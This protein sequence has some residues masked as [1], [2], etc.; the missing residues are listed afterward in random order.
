M[1]RN[2]AQAELESE[3]RHVLIV[4]QTVDNAFAGTV[5]IT[6]SALSLNVTDPKAS[7][8]WVAA[9]LGFAEEMSADGFVSMAHPQAGVNL[10]YLRVGLPTFTPASA[11]GHADGLLIAFVVDDLD[12]EYD[13]M[14][15]EGVEF[16]ALPVTEPW[17]E[18]YV[19][20]A[21][22]NGVVYQLVTWVTPPE[23]EAGG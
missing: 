4:A 8:D 22:P 1:G 15:R 21:D 17:G 16:L 20:A 6:R 18:R 2:E 23:G 5:D 3:I 10:I 14:L 13:R 19:Q 12:S 11:A 9:H 7:A